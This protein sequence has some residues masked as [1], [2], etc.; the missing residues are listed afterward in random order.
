MLQR[1]LQETPPV[2]YL[3]G[4]KRSH[5]VAVKRPN[6][7][8]IKAPVQGQGLR[9]ASLKKV[10]HFTNPI[11]RRS[12]ANRGSARTSSNIG[13]VPAATSIGSRSL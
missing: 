3:K 13:S 10:S 1:D 9:D 7:T 5:Q 4:Q 2:A 6:D 8:T 12:S 11:R